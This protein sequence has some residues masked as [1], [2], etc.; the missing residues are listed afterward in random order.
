MTASA[1]P[2]GEIGGHA[3]RLEPESHALDQDGTSPRWTL[4]QTH[5]KSSHLAIGKASI[6]SVAAAVGLGPAV[7]AA[8]AGSARA[9]AVALRR[10]FH[11]DTKAA[12]G[13][14]RVDTRSQ[15]QGLAQRIELTHGLQIECLG[16]LPAG[17]FL[18]GLRIGTSTPGK[19]RQ[20]DAGANTNNPGHR[21]HRAFI[22]HVR[23][24]N[25]CRPQ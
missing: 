10:G 11:R 23:D 20:D 24:N 6:G 16:S 9:G 1:R 21:Q 2:C 13:T 25:R 7:L 12:A 15:P 3:M 18:E 8:V 5:H 22:V 4:P 14:D 17:Q 19:Q